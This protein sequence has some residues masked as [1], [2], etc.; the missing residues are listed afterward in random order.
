MQEWDLDAVLLIVMAVAV[1]AILIIA[2]VLEF[3]SDFAGELR[4]LNNE[5][6]RAVG[7]DRMHWVRQRR[8]LWLSLI[9]FVK[10]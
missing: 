3:I 2:K 1:M 7:K 10:Y 8:R 5:I 4:Y 9:P 6:R